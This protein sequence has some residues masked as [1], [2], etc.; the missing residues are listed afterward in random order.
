MA[1]EFRDETCEK[2]SSSEQAENPMKNQSWKT[3]RELGAPVG[4]ECRGVGN[5]NS[6][7]PDIEEDNIMKPKKKEDENK[8]FRI[9]V[10]IY[11]NFL[12]TIA[13]SGISGTCSQGL[14]LS[15]PNPLTLTLM[16][17][18][19][20]LPVNHQNHLNV[21]TFTDNIYFSVYTHTTVTRYLK[22]FC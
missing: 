22:V 15:K 6:R 14:I 20:T 13:R 18:F 7:H 4:K 16:R 2:N 5:F 8:S 11:L 21:G 10:S 9:N 12:I 1:V 19:T 17:Y 3:L